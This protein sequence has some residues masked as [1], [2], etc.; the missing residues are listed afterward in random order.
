[1]SATSQMPASV[2]LF[3]LVMLALS[4][5]AATTAVRALGPLQEVARVDLRLSDFQLA[6]LQGPAL[7][8]PTVLAA[9]PLGILVDRA[10]RTRLL[11]WLGWIAV[12]G[13]V[14]TALAPNFIVLVIGRCMVGL[15][16]N[17]IIITGFSMLA[18][19]YSADQRGRAKSLL[20]LSQYGGSSV[21]FAAGGAIL[22]H[23]AGPDGWRWAVG[24]VTALMVFALLVQLLALRE[25]VRAERAEASPTT[26]RTIAELWRYR[27][28]IM[29][30][31]LGLVLIEMPVF[32]I[33]AWAAPAFSRNLQLS[34]EVVG[35]LVGSAM[36]A[37]GL[38]GPVLG[39]TLADICQRFGGPRLTVSVLA[40]MS[41]ITAPGGLFAVADSA[42]Q[43][44]ILIAVC[45]T[46]L[47]ATVSMGVTLF[48]VAVPNELRGLSLALL[49]ATVAL[50]SASLAPLLVTFIA[51]GF[52]GNGAVANA[53]AVICGGAGTLGAV[54][55]WLA[56]RSFP[57]LE[58]A[59]VAGAR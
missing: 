57:K 8:L 39:G 38:I 2:R 34:S 14:A 36:L 43:A 41:L 42:T 37:S 31:I 55:Y 49:S 59:L 9:I 4:A 11:Q 32:A 56:R 19:L 23:V 48:T 29:P 16:C 17:A 47:S 20:V 3:Q 7:N 33:V 44:G 27:A 15:A 28:I 1:M 10:T 54:T 18:D 52:E 40:L 45:M 30:L 12:S 6:I 26:S 22:G 46:L 5:F 21:A 24:A 35:A 51:G 53:I 58:P 13:G 50:F 25:P